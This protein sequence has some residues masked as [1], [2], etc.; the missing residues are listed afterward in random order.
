[1]NNKECRKYLENLFQTYVFCKANES[2]HLFIKKVEIVL[3]LLDIKHRNFIKRVFIDKNKYYE[4]GYKRAMYYR[5]KNI[6]AKKFLNYASN[7]YDQ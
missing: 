2:N 1:M 4:T 6:C 7:I 5:M 3:N